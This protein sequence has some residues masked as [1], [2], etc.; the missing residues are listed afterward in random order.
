MD[1]VDANAS[2]GSFSVSMDTTA[3][4]VSSV[5]VPANATYVA[6]DNLYFTVNTTENVTVNTGGGTP[7][8][9][10]TIGATGKTASYVSGTGTSALVFRYTVESGLADTDGIAVGGSIT[11]NSGTMKDAAG[12]DLT[13]TLNSVGSLT[14]VLVDSTA[15]TVSSVSVPANAT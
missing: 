9:A 2:A 12:N 14:A 6:G 15:P 8:L 3:P 13:T 1:Y 10:L 5:S 4:T 11:L 7:T